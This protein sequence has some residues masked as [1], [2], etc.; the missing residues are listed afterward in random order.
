MVQAPSKHR[1]EWLDGLRGIAVVMVVW[2]HANLIGH[3]I[4]SLPWFGHNVYF[5]QIP[6]VGFTGVELFFFISG[7]A[8]FYPYARNLFE[9]RPLDDLPTF[10][11]RRFIK[12][13]PSYVIVLIALVLFGGVAFRTVSDLLWTLFVHLAFILSDL[14]THPFGYINGALWSLSVEVQFYLVFPLLARAMRRYPAATWLA[15]CFIA[16]A[17]RISTLWIGTQHQAFKTQVPAYLDLFACGMFA[18][19]LCV[20]WRTRLTPTDPA[21][22]DRYRDRV[23]PL[24]C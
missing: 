18:A 11:W 16:W 2:F 19:Y 22:S 7:F 4:P 3:Y 14:D 6:A 20:R 10:A 23:S 12:I 21:Q 13:V 1:I 17:Y 9:S 5:E 24:R 8:L 15:C